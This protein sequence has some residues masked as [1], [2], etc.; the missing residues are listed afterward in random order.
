MVSIEIIILKQNS[1]SEHVI[2]SFHKL[3]SLKLLVKLKMKIQNN[4]YGCMNLILKLII[5]RKKLLMRLNKYNK[6]S[7]LN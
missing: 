5:F 6:N 2:K 3:K 7:N 4:S 1:L